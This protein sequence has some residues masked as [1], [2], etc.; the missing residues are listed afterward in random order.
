MCG[1][2]N[3]SFPAH[4]CLLGSGKLFWTEE[5]ELKTADLRRGDVYRLKAGAVFFIES[6]LETEAER[7]KLR[8]NSIFPN[9]KTD[10]HVNNT[11]GA[12]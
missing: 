1:I 9:S 7:Q 5:S 2:L 12:L 6:N 4:L 11:F 8:I 10:M 3:F